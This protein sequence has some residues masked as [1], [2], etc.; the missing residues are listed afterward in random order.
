[1]RKHARLSIKLACLLAIGASAH[2]VEPVM[3]ELTTAVTLAAVDG[4]PLSGSWS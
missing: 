1:M 3:V 4:S 2:D